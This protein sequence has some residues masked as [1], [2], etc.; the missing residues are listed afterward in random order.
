M[1]VTE[2][3]DPLVESRGDIAVLGLGNVL[4]GD[5]ALGPTVIAH[6]NARFEFPARVQV[7]D[8]GT[9][10][11]DLHPHLAGRKVLIIID[12]VRSETAA[13]G[14]LRLYRKE[15]ILRHPPAARTGPHDPSLKHTLL[16]LQFADDDPEDVLLVGVVPE[17]TEGSDEMTAPVQAAVPA[18]VAAVIEELERLG[19]PAR[20]RAEPAEP[21]L[22][23][24]ES[25]GT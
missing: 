10:G 3:T 15:Q 14:E 16:T 19:E 18:A 5:D 1:R 9:P 8:L 20:P 4:M 11:F 21:H 22:W 23:W 13:A 17:S 12:T 25:S 2:T 24:Q 7:E 6:L